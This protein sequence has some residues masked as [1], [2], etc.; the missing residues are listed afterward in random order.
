ML[1]NILSRLVIVFLPRS[2]HLNFTAA[3]TICSDFG[4]Q[5]NKVSHCFPIYFHE[6]MGPDKLW[7]EVR[8]IVQEKRIKTIPMKKKCKKAKWLS[9]E[10][11]KIAVKRR[12]VKG[13]GDKERHTHLN[14]EFKRIARRGKKVFLNEKCKEIEQC[15]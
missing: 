5:E 1:F 3:V 7:M 13:K 15:K 8:D 10:A 9:E 6:V 14:A 11:L 12:E 2:K 4:A